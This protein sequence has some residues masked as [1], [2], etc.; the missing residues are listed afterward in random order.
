[1]NLLDTEGKS[2]SGSPVSTT[3]NTRLSGSWLIVARIVWL[4]LVVPSLGLFIVSLLVAYKQ[5][6]TVC[7]DPVTCNLSGA[8][9]PQVQQ[10]LPTIGL[11]LS[12]FAA[13]V[14]IF[15]AITAAIWYGVGFLIFWRRSDDWL[16]LL[17][18]FFLVM[19]NI[20]NSGNSASALALAYPILALPLSLVNFLG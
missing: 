20:T 16:A 10:A 11:S 8:L 2:A 5:M 13:L 14:T 3:T 7:V 4:A 17:A 9:P 1:M 6:Q 19:F 15:F 12:G 18:A